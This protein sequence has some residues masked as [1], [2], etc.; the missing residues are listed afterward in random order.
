MTD[1]EKGVK[2][3]CIAAKIWMAVILSSLIFIAF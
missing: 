1:Y 2:A 3:C